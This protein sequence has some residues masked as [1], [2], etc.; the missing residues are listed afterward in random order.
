MII[1]EI[2]IPKLNETITFYVG[3]NK[4]DNFTIIDNA[5]E[6]DLWFH[7]DDQASCHVVAS[8][9]DLQLCNKKLLPII[10]QGAL[11]CKKNSKYKSNKDISIVYTKIKSVIKTEII[12]TVNLL[13][14]KIIII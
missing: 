9:N 5:K 10:K 7:I 4:F 8:V 12:G 3:K 14:N 2:F 6:N 13:E 1:E 11:L